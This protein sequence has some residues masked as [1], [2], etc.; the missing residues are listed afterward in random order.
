MRRRV[1]V[2]NCAVLALAAAAAVAAVSPAWNHGY[3]GWWPGGYG[4]PPLSVEAHGYFCSAT[5]HGPTFH[6]KAG[7]WTQD[8]GAGTSCLGGVGTKTLT[9]AN[10][11][12]GQNRHTWFTISGS[13][14]KG[15]PTTGNPLRLRRT[16]AAHLGHAY[17]TI[18]GATLVVPNGHAGCSLT[19]SCDQTIVIRAVSRPLA[20]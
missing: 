13:A 2:L 4:Y 9:V 19:N 6:S 12:L 20:P 7:G 16:R 14:V 5:V 1:V 15:G 3:N 11:V 17:R 18:V 10:Q 8:Y